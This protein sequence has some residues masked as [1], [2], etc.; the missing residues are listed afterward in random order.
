[1][2]APFLFEKKINLE[3]PTMKVTIVTT[4][5]TT[6]HDRIYCR[7]PKVEF[8]A[9]HTIDV[10]TFTCESFVLIDSQMMIMINTTTMNNN[11]SHFRSQKS[12]NI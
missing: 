3:K 4:V 1:M 10:E 2:V 8:D 6:A 7:P 11:H 5:T 9:F 12:K